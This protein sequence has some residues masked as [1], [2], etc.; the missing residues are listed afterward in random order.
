MKGG[1][2]QV[3]GQLTVS[4]LVAFIESAAT[5]SLI[6]AP[7]SR[8]QAPALSKL[9]RS[10]RRLVLVTAHSYSRLDQSISLTR[11]STPPSLSASF[12]TNII[13]G[14]YISGEGMHREYHWRVCVNLVTGVKKADYD[15]A[16]RRSLLAY[17]CDQGMP[18]LM[19]QRPYCWY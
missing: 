9:P 5:W 15:T 18:L 17:V 16:H 6:K 10:P 12:G 14:S 1:H 13:V 4:A 8:F 7:V 2:T 3:V 11:P 19:M